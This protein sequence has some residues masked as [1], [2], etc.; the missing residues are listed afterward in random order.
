MI[1]KSRWIEIGKP[2]LVQLGP[3]INISMGG[4]SVQYIENKKRVAD[5]EVLAVSQS[6]GSLKVEPIPF[7]IVTDLEAARMPDGKKIRNRHV[8]FR[9]L[10]DYQS[11]QLESFIRKHTT[12]LDTDRRMG[13]ERRQYDDPRFKDEEYK[14]MYERRFRMDR[15][16]LL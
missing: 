3:V 5:S 14:K 10:T 4:L 9:K 6:P 11:F 2:K 12:D 15:R 13:I 1:Q 8:E 16:A 7:R